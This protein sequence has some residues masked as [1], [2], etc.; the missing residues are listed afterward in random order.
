MTFD[1]LI[2][3]TAGYVGEELV[4]VNGVYDS[5]STVIVNKIKKGLNEAKNKLAK[6]YEMLTTETITLDS[7][8][9]FLTT[10]L[11]KTLNYIKDVKVNK[12]SVGF[13]EIYDNVVKCDTNPSINVNV[14]YF[15][16]PDDMF[17]LIDEQPF[18]LKIQPNCLCY[19]AAY[20]YLL[21]QGGDSARKKAMDWLSLWNKAIG[22]IP[23]S[24]KPIKDVYG[25]N[26]NG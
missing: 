12:R 7:N 9:S 13:K 26:W 8:S 21:M 17:L 1:D 15:Y 5:D 24:F 14:E 11:M 16:I 2:Q 25:V 4:K 6:I 22:S 23:Q 19:F 3:E 10:D 20:K 18:P